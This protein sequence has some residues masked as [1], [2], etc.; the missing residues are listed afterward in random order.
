MMESSWICD[1]QCSRAAS[2]CAG[3]REAQEQSLQSFPVPISHRERFSSVVSNGT[4]MIVRKV[5]SKD[6]T[7]PLKD[8]E[9]MI[10]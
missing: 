2:L 5:S 7:P 8:G 9:I 6:I 4:G 3:V 10:Q 1:V